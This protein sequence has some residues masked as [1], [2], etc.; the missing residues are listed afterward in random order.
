MKRKV[1]KDEKNRRKKICSQEIDDDNNNIKTISTLNN[2]YELTRNQR[3]WLMKMNNEF[4][5]TIIQTSDGCHEENVHLCSLLMMN[6][7]ILNALKY[8]KN[9]TDMIKEFVIDSSVSADVLRQIIY[10]AYHMNASLNEINSIETA[11]FAAKYHIDSLV[12][13]CLR[14]FQDNCTIRNVLKGFKISI[15]IGSNYR[16]FFQSFIEN[17]FQKIFNSKSKQDLLT[18]NDCSILEI[19]GSQRLD[20]RN[21]E[22]IWQIIYDWIDYDI[23]GRLK[24]V[25]H[26]LTNVLRFGRLKDEFLKTK[27]FGCNLFQQLEPNLQTR[28]IKWIDDLNNQTVVIRDGYGLKYCKH[29]LY[30]QPRET[31]ELLLVGG[32]WV[33]GSTTNSLELYDYQ[34]NL[35]LRCPLILKDKIS[36]F[37]LEMIND[38][39]YVFGGSNGTDVFQYL[40]AFNLNEPQRQWT[41]KCSMIERRCYVS[42]ANLN[43]QL[44]AIGGFNRQTRVR[45]CERYNPESDSWQYVAELNY[46]RSDASAI[47]HDG[48]IFIAGGINDSG[49]ES[50]AEIYYP[51][52]NQW[53]LIRSMS[54][55]RTSFSIVSF[56]NKIWALGGNDGSKRSG[57]VECY[58]PELNVW[59]EA[60][61][62]LIKRSTFSAIILKDELY[63]VGGYNGQSP[64]CDVEKYVPNIGWVKV[65]P[66]RHDRSGLNLLCIP[67]KYDF[68]KI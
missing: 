48:K 32:G 46:G 56:Q 4:I 67:N 35:W 43:G 26:A 41:S 30:Y 29:S 40:H 20:S 58:D 36:Y 27:I 24:Y 37:G 42:S 61:N 16:S 15:Q 53:R 9:R 49:I 17:N 63:V 57:S 50:S 11:E 5:D 45:S 28:L 52:L 31:K 51:Q 55:P 34:T 22:Q 19:I 33:E 18:I 64:I 62:M 3:L 14:Y 2:S 21:E 7:N 23:P 8:S 65:K 38:I 1:Q 47:V 66:L 44:Y 6:E 54:S 60:E 39:V 25:E 68:L 10:F 59:N 12:D 13:Y